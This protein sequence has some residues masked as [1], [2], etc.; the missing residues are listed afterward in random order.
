MADNNEKYLELIT[1]EY[2]QNAK[3]NSY[4]KAFLDMCSP[5]VVNY[6]DFAVLFN[7]ENAVGDQ[8][9]KIG[10]LVGIGRKLPFESPNV[11]TVLTDS[12]YRKVI[13]SKIYINHWDG[14]MKQMA[15]IF[16]TVF[17]DLPFD[18]IDNQNMT[19]DI[20]IVDPNMSDEDEVILK[21]GF[22]V[23]K[24]SGVKVNYTVRREEIF[25]WDLS[26]SFVKGWDKGIWSNT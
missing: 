8:L 14:T 5:T 18:I 19:Y 24:P 15:L 22:T 11:S 23:P 9:D 7:L 4:V 26:N 16:S 20:I 2:S 1:S 17:K 6:Q 25:G 13:K 10:E 3:Y 21:Y 12:Q